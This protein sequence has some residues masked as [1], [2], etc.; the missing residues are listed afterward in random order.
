MGEGRFF[1]AKADA[2]RQPTPWEA[3]LSTAGRAWK[4]SI[5]N[6]VTNK[7]IIK[8]NGNKFKIIP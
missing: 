6:S 7:H 8:F 1:A 4:D 3:P 2:L 5:R